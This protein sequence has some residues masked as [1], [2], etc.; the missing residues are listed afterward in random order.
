MLK[1]ANADRLPVMIS[2]GCSTAYCAPLPPY[3]GYVDIHGKTH[4]GTNGGEVF[5]SPPPPPLPLQPHP[6]V[7]VSLGEASVT[8][9]ENGAVAYIGCNTGGQPC[10]LTLLEGFAEAL[11]KE[12]SPR[13]GDAWMEAV[14]YYYAK[15]RLAQLKPNADWYPPSIF[16]QGMKYMV[17]GDPSLVLPGAEGE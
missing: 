17:F 14:R 12:K 9:G 7:P 2:A 8:A 1:A 6:L 11:G 15:E 16:F 3:E 4:R 13:L 5:K 10:A